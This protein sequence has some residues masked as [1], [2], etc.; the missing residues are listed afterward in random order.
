MSEADLVSHNRIVHGTA[1]IKNSKH[2]GSRIC[3]HKCTYNEWVWKG[4]LDTL[5]T[6][7]SQNQSRSYLTK[8]QKEVLKSNLL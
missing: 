5:S 1:T 6:L 3:L 8:V 7:E 4:L 2:L